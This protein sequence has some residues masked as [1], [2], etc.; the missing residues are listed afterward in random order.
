MC[1]LLQNTHDKNWFEPTRFA[2]ILFFF[3]TLASTILWHEECK[4]WMPL[5]LS[6]GG[7]STHIHPYKSLET[8]NNNSRKITKK[9]SLIYYMCSCLQRRF[10]CLQGAH[11]QRFYLLVSNMNYSFWATSNVMRTMCLH[12]LVDL[13]HNKTTAIK[14]KVS[15]WIEWNFSHRFSASML[16]NIR[17]FL[18]LD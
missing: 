2:F 8:N 11:F 18:S 7:K 4:Y 1:Y 15:S 3:S 6:N 16:Q 10:R 13:C 9:L 14:C 5:S 17:L 12:V